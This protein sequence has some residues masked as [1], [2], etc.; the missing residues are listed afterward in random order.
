MDMRR[1]FERQM[2]W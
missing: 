2:S 1:W